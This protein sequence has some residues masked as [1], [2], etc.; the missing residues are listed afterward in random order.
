AAENRHQAQAAALQ[1]KIDAQRADNALAQAEKN[2]AWEITKEAAK[3]DVEWHQLQVAIKEASDARTRQQL[4]EKADLVAARRDELRELAE[5]T[6]AALAEVRPTGEITIVGD[7]FS[8][9]QVEELISKQ[10]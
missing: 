6:A 8:A 2:A 1:A 5:S 7:A 9:Q 3:A 4:Q 10:I